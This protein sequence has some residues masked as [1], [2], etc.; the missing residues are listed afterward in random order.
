M[1]YKKHILLNGISM[2]KIFLLCGSL[3]LPTLL[4]AAPA[5]SVL[6]DVCWALEDSYL[7]L[8]SDTE[9]NCKLISERKLT[10]TDIYALG[11]KVVSVNTTDGGRGRIGTTLLVEKRKM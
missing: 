2:K 9:F 5:N 8:D 7:A 10:I 1:G 11:Y 3:L 6:V 4:Q